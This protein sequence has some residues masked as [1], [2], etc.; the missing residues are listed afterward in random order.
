MT[1]WTGGEEEEGAG[2][3]R[4][5]VVDRRSNS[6]F[7]MDR[8]ESPSSSATGR[9]TLCGAGSVEIPSSFCSSTS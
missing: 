5:S 6:H 3:V 7:S 8:E 4:K 9:V 1:C 2:E